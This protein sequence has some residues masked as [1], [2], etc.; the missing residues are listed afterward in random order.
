MPTEAQQ[1]TYIDNLGI[2][3]VTEEL[4]D[5]DDNFTLL[6]YELLKNGRD[7]IVT[8]NGDVVVHQG[9]VVTT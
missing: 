3:R 7:N 8:H 1:Q 9:N 5:Y 6:L 4:T 2:T